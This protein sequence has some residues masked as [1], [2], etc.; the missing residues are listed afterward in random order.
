MEEDFERGFTST[1]ANVCGDCIGDS[2]LAEFVESVAED[3]PCTYCGHETSAALDDVLEHMLEAVRLEYRPA[4]EESPPW[5]SAE[6]GYQARE[7]WFPE[8]L[9]EEMDDDFGDERVRDDIE[10]ALMPFSEPWFE[11]DFYALRPHQQLLYSWRRFAIAVQQRRSPT[12]RPP[13]RPSDDPDVW[14]EPSDMLDTIAERLGDLPTAIRTLQAGTA[15]WRARGGTHPGTAAELGPPPAGTHVLGGRMN[16]PEQIFFYGAVD[17]DTAVRETAYKSGASLVTVGRFQTVREL[18]CLDL[19]GSGL[20][21]PS[22]FDLAAQ[23]GRTTVRFL[24]EFGA[25]IS[26]PAAD[27][28]P[29]GYF[30]TQA[31]TEYVRTELGSHL[32]VEIH[33]ML[34]PSARAPGTNAVLFVDS[35]ACADDGA[36]QT[37]A[38]RLVLIEA[39]G[40]TVLHS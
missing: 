36:L 17:S 19:T 26:L 32:G 35:Q 30:P 33:G 12:I 9:W 27:K 11:R 28:H 31:V 24:R 18:V 37:P 15:L 22:I 8:L 7:V 25:L 2:V 34:Y 5:D 21:L 3:E 40:E 16:Q 10:S 14:V 29:R 23:A 1:G 4:S 6:G 13:S 38:T 20:K 39:R